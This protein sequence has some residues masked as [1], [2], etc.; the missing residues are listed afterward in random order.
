MCKAAVPW[1]NTAIDPNDPR[2]R[3]VADP[4][5]ATRMSDWPQI[6]QN[7]IILR[8]DFSTISLAEYCNLIL[9]SLGLVKFGVVLNHFMAKF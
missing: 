9:K 6:G 3:A 7:T 4:A 8:S 2:L 1:V 5:L